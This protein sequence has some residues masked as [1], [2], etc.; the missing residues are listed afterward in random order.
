MGQDLSSPVSDLETIVLEIERITQH[1]TKAPTPSEW[2]EISRCMIAF[3]RIYGKIVADNP[4]HSRADELLT[5][6]KR[7]E[8]RMNQLSSPEVY[9][10]QT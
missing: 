1:I 4:T 3:K 8:L 5:R 10:Y 9:T 7:V 2:T 6:Y